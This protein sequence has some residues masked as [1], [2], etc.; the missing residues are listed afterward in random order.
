[1]ALKIPDENKIDAI[2]ISAICGKMEIDESTLIKNTYA[3]MH[4]SNSKKVLSAFLYYNSKLE[5]EKIGL[6]ILTSNDKEYS[7]SEILN[8]A[9]YLRI[10]RGIKI[11]NKKIG[12]NMPCP[13]GSGKKYKKCCGK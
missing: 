13:C 7:Y 11:E 1:M 12:R 2:C 10:K 6:K 4:L 3:N 9:E 8:A 5:V